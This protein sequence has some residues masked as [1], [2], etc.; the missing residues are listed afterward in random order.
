VANEAD[1]QVS[2]GDGPEQIRGDC[3]EQNCKNHKV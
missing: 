1:K 3:D 2:G